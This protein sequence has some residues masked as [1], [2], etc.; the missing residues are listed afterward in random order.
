MT[1]MHDEDPLDAARDARRIKSEDL[2]ISL[3]TDKISKVHDVFSDGTGKLCRAIRLAGILLNYNR[4]TRRQ[5]CELPPASEE[6]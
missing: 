6:D 4:R 5:P 3:L 1:A 2:T